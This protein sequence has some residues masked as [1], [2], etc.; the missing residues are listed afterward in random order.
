MPLPAIG[1]ENPPFDDV[2]N[3][4]NVWANA[5]N[6]NARSGT[7]NNANHRSGRDANVAIVLMTIKSSRTL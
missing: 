4:K 3:M 6:A 2:N 1:N 5:A 7:D